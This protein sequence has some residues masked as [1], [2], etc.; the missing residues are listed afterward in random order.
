M[1]EIKY[2]QEKQYLQKLADDYAREKPHL[3]H[4]LDPQD[5][6]TGYLLEGFA[7]LSAR[8]QEKID[9]AFPE[10][11]LPLLQRLGSQAIK[12]LPST[13][14]IQVD[15]DG[16]IDY[17]Y[18]LSEN[19][20]ILGP[21]G[22][23]FSLCYGVTLQPYSIV[24]RKI[25]HQPNRSCISLRVKYRGIIKE[26][27]TASLNLFLSK[28]KAIADTL[29]LGFSQY[30]DYIELNHDG[31][32]YRGNSLDFY[33]EPKIGKKFQIFQQTDNQ[34][35]AP[36]QLLEGFYL[37][38]VHH[39]IDINV[40]LITKQLNWQDDDTFVI[41]I[42]FNKQLSITQ[43]QCEESF[44]LNCVPAIDKEK[45]NELKIDFKYNQ[46]SYLLPIPDNHYLAHLSDIQL[47]LEP[48]EKVRGLYCD[49]YP[50][51]DF[52]AASRLLPQYQQA[53]FYA[54]T[55]DN[56]IRGRT[57]YYLN[58]YDNKGTPMVVPPSLRFSCNYVSFE[59]Y[60]ESRI[61]VLNSHSEKVPEG[62]KTANITEL[63]NCYPPIVNDKYYWQLL[64]HY[65]AN[66]FMLMSLDTIKQMLTE[67][68]LYR[69]NDRQVTRKLERLLSGC[70]AL[71]TNLYDHILKGKPYRCL[72]LVVTLD[73]QKFENEGEAFMFVTHLYHFFPFCLSENMLLEMSVNFNDADLPTWYLSPSQLQGY[74]SLL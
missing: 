4:V 48:H 11:T 27:D 8:L 15:Q 29:M 66:A 51:T 36:Q 72:S 18:Y 41:N 68:I 10:I 30:F 67:Y 33:F 71:K 45:Q 21:K 7:F 62:V 53:L 47:S 25:T 49:F 2:L 35:S 56:D 3:V 44:Y 14:I 64:S 31:K 73:I 52:T 54:L 19:N 22:A 37:P 13:T 50:M 16:V 57:L 40:P 9:D 74:K 63:S 39:F 55:I 65:S 43:A 34:L 70:I 42:Y 23:S 58:F 12:G 26:Y 24:E 46:S 1:S 61:G 59:Q 17:P 5:P 32:S 6:H 38:H 28:Q 69:E 20:L 60:Q